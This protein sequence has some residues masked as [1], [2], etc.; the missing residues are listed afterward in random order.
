VHEGIGADRPTPQSSERERGREGACGLAPRGGVRLSGAK[1]ARA[2]AGLGLLCR[3][4]L[5]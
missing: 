1:G 4:G 2:R 3:L 5:K